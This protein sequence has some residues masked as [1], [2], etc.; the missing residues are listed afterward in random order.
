[1][2][3]R[4]GFVSNSSSSS[5]ICDICGNSETV[6]DG[7]LNEAGMFSCGLHTICDS[8]KLEPS[9]AEIRQSLTEDINA[10]II[11][12]SQH[13]GDYY[14]KAVKRFKKLLI[15]IEAPEGVVSS[16]F[17]EDDLMDTADTW[18]HKENEGYS[19]SCYCPVCQLKEILPEDA[20]KYVKVAM[21]L[22]PEKEIR[23]KFKD[24][25]HLNQWL[26][27]TAEGA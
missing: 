24:L 14:V 21:N 20:L 23:E 19:L 12:L 8:H 18:Q 17:N 25:G 11:R 10:A 6:W 4:N 1:M 3:I 16:V 9:Q 7:D 27:E 2:K 5:F 22:D 26:K 15:K 13:T